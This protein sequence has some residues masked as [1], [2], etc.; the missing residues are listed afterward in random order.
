MGQQVAGWLVVVL[1]LAPAIVVG[2]ASEQ[3]GTYHHVGTAMRLLY[4]VPAALLLGGL[5]VGLGW[6]L[7]RDS[8][9]VGI[10]FVYPMIYAPVAA[11]IFVGYCNV[12]LDES[13]PRRIE[14]V[15]RDRQKRAKRPNRILLRDWDAPSETIDLPDTFRSGPVVHLEVHAG[16]LGLRWVREVDSP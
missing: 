10:A 4:T 13:P 7:L 12:A 1:S 2:V 14:A 15:V 16:A 5:L 3:K 8:P 11:F 6:L 9:L